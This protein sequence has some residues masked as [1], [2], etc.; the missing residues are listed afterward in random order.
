[1]LSATGKRLY[2]G[3]VLCFL[4]FPW[5]R[6][7]LVIQMITQ[8][9]LHPGKGNAWTQIRPWKRELW[10]QTNQFSQLLSIVLWDVFTWLCYCM[11]QGPGAR[12]RL[13]DPQVKTLPLCQQGYPIFRVSCLVLGRSAA[14]RLLHYLGKKQQYPCWHCCSVVAW[15]AGSPG[16]PPCPCW[17]L[18]C[19]E[20]LKAIEEVEKVKKCVNTEKV[21]W[22][23]YRWAWDTFSYL[24]GIVEQ[25][26]KASTMLQ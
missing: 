11:Y 5:E 18:H 3:A 7:N 20:K 22:R 13:H 4:L 2:M 23:S 12:P 15:G 19:C 25:L 14:L 21:N 9:F 10:R 6:I 8:A 17:I 16:F 24:V 1:M 26:Q